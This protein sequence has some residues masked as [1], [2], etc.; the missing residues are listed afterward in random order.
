MQRH[1]SRNGELDPDRW[2]RLNELKGWEWSPRADRW[3][4]RFR[5]LV[6]YVKQNGKSLPNRK[7]VEK[8]GY[9]LGAWVQIQRH[10]GN[11]GELAP[12]RWRSLDKLY[13]WDWQPARGG[14]A[15]RR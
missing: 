6:A 5:R 10:R 2:K 9:R 8:D 4:E 13:G 15:S 14:V 11:K 3:N 7:Y 1:L 12:D